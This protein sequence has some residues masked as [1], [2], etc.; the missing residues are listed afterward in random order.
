MTFQIGEKVVY[1]N[2]GVG[3]IE[4]ISIRS[5]G[6]DLEKYYLLRFGF[7][8][9]TV[10]V[11][12]SNAA[13]IGLRR[14]THDREISRILSF[15]ANGSRPLN[16]EWKARFKENTEK[17]NSGDLLK[18]AEVFKSLLLVH[19][20]K[21]LSFRE[22]KMMDQARRM[23]VAEISTA[24]DIPEIRATGLLQHALEKTGLSLPAE[25]LA[26]AGA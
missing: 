8:G 21:P 15:L 12:L 7:S 9:A 6:P 26:A 5:S 19:A 18:A 16:P 23:L 2:Q 10:M 17:M 3:T 22:K 20:E 13:T 25:S 11:P 14:V 4:N 24:R 1:P